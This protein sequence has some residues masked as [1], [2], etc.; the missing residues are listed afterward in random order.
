MEQKGRFGTKQKKDAE[1]KAALVEWRRQGSLLRPGVFLFVSLCLAR[2]VWF[3]VASWQ[4]ERQW[5][6]VKVVI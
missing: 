1:E 2:L 5:R 3:A 6:T 4:A